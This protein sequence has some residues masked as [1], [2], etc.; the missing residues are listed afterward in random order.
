MSAKAFSVTAY[1][2]SVVSNWL[3][4]QLN[5]KFPEKETIHGKLVKKLRYGEN[6]HQEGSLY[7]TNES[8]DI[9]K[10]HGKGLS[11]NNYNDIYS[12]IAILNTFKTVKNKILISSH[13]DLFFK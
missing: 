1:Y 7:A 2:D 9:K 11:Y 13:N 4:N 12:A 10:I 3:N 8:L 6:P 5:I